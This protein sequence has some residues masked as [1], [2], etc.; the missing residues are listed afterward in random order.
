MD[1]AAGGAGYAASILNITTDL[2]VDLWE[3][4]SY[5]YALLP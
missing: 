4:K 2:H 1:G 3:I 5:L